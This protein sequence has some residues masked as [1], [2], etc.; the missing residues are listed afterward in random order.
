[1][2]K[3]QIQYD[4][5]FESKAQ[6]HGGEQLEFLENETLCQQHNTLKQA[7]KTIL[8]Y[9]KETHELQMKLIQVDCYRN[10]A[11]INRILANR[12]HFLV[13][14]MKNLQS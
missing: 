13:F 5:Y 1:M 9:K 11:V 14:Q 3:L 6:H 10:A 2:N 7:S 12:H 4:Q 8:Q